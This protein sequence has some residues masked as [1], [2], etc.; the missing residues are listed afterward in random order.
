MFSSKGRGPAG[1]LL[2]V[3]M[4]LA[5][6]AGLMACET[7]GRTT[8]TGDSFTVRDG[9]RFYTPVSASGAPAIDLAMAGCALAQEAADEAREKYNK[10]KREWEENPTPATRAALDAA[11]RDLRFA[12]AAASGACARVWRGSALTPAAADLLGPVIPPCLV[13]DCPPWMFDTG[14]R[15]DLYKKY[16]IAP[17]AGDPWPQPSVEGLLRPDILSFERQL[18]LARRLRADLH[19]RLKTVDLHIKAL[20]QKAG[21]TL[22]LPPPE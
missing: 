3:G 15:D 13:I 22:P 2:R 10:K 18:D 1:G 4:A 9:L 21:P 7:P 5:L 19:R 12:E 17:K 11:Q 14:I 20:K 6:A 16:R 8:A